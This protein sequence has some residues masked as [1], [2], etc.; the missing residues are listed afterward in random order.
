MKV[1]IFYAQKVIKFHHV[2]AAEQ[3]IKWMQATKKKVLLPCLLRVSMVSYYRPFSFSRMNRFQK[4]LSIVYQ[5]NGF[6]EN[7]TN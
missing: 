6:V 1:L 4:I 2:K 5:V 7:E 3:F